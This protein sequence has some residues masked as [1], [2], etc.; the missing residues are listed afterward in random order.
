MP[1]AIDTA[2][3]D[4]SKIQSMVQT[5]VDTSEGRLGSPA[6]ATTKGAEKKQGYSQRRQTTVGGSVGSL[7]TGYAANASSDL[8]SSC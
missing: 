1:P 3:P 7:R 5:A 8:S 2:D 4:V 6:D